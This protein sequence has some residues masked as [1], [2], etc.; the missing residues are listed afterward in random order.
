MPAV[1]TVTGVAWLQ[2]GAW[3]VS[4]LKPS[5]GT[6]CGSIAYPLAALLI[7]LSVFQLIL[8]PGIRFY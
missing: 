2:A 3:R 7:L 1:V 6:G 5:G 4:G 8:R